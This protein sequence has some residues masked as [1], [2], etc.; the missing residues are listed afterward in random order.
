[1]RAHA[2]QGAKCIIAGSGD[3]DRRSVIIEGLCAVDLVEGCMLA[4][5]DPQTAARSRRPNRMR[6]S[7]LFSG[8][9]FVN[10]PASAG[11]LK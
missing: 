2:R 8:Q 6:L 10:I 3:K 4:K 11:L 7:M 5:I 1:M 9:P